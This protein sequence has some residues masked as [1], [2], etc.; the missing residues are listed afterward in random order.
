MAKMLNY[1]CIRSALAVKPVIIL[2]VLRAM[3]IK[4]YRLHYL[5]KYV[6]HKLASIIILMLALL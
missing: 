5:V 3:C 6:I 4:Y 1:D 2:I